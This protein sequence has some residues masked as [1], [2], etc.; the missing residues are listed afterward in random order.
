MN[1]K[2]GPSIWPVSLLARGAPS[3]QLQRA[4][5]GFQILL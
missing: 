5:H 2:T 1:A 4:G 3:D